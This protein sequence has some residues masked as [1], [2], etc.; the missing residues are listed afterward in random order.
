MLRTAANKIVLFN[1]QA[2]P[3]TKGDTACRLF[4]MGGST[5]YGRPYRDAGS[6]CGWLRAYLGAADPGRDWV[7]INAGGISYASYRVARLMAGLTQYQPDLFDVY[8][9]QN[10]FL[11]QRSYGRLIDL[12][13]WLIDLN[14]WLSGSRICT[15]ISRAIDSVTPASSGL[16]RERDVLDG[17]VDEILNHSIGPQSYQRDDVPRRQ[18]VPPFRLNLL[19]MTDIARKAGAEVVFVLPAVNLKDMSP[20]KSE[21]GEGLDAQARE[22]WQA[23]YERAAE[24]AVEGIADEALGA[25]CKALAIDNR[26]AELHY[27]TGRVLFSAGRYDEAKKAFRR[28]VEEDIAPLRILAPMQQALAEVAAS[29]D[30]SLVSFPDIIREACLEQYPQA[31]FGREFFVVHV[32]TNMEGYRRLGLALLD[33]LVST[34]IANPVD[35]RDRA[36]QDAVTREVIAAVD[37]RDEGDALLNLGKVLEW[38]GKFEE[39]YPLFQ[40]TLEILGP[41]PMLYD[42]LART[43]YAPGLHDEVIAYLEKILSLAPT[44]RGVHARLAVLLSGQGETARAIGHCEAE[45]LLRPGDYIVRAR[46]AEL[47]ERQGE[48][49]SAM[50]QYRKVLQARPDLARA[51]LRLAYLLIR[52]DQAAEA[53]Q[54]GQEALRIEPGLYQAHHVIGLAMQRQ[55]RTDEAQHHFSE[56]R[57]H[58]AG[59]ADNGQGQVLTVD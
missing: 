23:L 42:R 56:A 7:V 13:G 15:A 45:L 55:G 31:V 48:D 32:H 47:H 12:P 8:T 3:K 58:E 43:A 46:L 41:G 54:H 29:A 16:A 25:C 17:E 38:A 24:L 51:L 20:F 6:F 57:R 22:R 33:T 40:R 30:L 18:V 34:G 44:A 50:A 10:E 27:R 36:E 37:I 49:A 39:A 53:L 11:E 14:A 4:C 19:R 28:A 26:H 9:G 5:T 52:Q 1:H 35:S 2:F 59:N 21:H